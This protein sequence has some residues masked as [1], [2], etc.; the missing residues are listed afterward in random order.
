MQNAEKMKIYPTSPFA[1]NQTKILKIDHSATPPTRRDA[2]AH[3]VCEI[4]FNPRATLNQ[5]MHLTVPYK[6]VCLL[7]FFRRFTYVHV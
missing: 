4:F 3:A 7:N 6:H 1:S 2:N 5:S